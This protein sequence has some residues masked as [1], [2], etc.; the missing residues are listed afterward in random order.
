MGRHRHATR[1]NAH[2]RP[3][4][5]EAN[6]RRETAPCG[7]RPPAATHS[8]QVPGLTFS[9]VLEL[10]SMAAACKNV[11]A[12]AK[13]WQIVWWIQGNVVPLWPN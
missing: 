13:K 6:A 9:Q 10:S 7:L 5:R 3:S 11:R 1:P 4:A 8:D 2:T 12:C